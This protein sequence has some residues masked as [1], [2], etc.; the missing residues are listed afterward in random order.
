MDTRRTVIQ[1]TVPTSSEFHSDDE[2]PPDPGRV[3][4]GSPPKRTRRSPSTTQQPT[5][6][7]IHEPA[8]RL[9]P[10][11]DHWPVKTRLRKRVR[12]PVLLE[13]AEVAVLYSPVLVSKGWNAQELLADQETAQVA[14]HIATVLANHAAGVQIMPCKPSL[15]ACLAKLD[16]ARHLIFNLCEGQ[17]GRKGSEAQIARIIAEHGFIHTGAPYAA[18]ARTANKWTT[19]KILE[20]AGLP[21]PAC[22]II[23]QSS[24][25]QLEVQPPVM[26][27]PIAEDGSIGITQRSLARTAEEALIMV[28][29]HLKKYR[30][31][32]LVEEYIA[33][34]EINVA[35][36]GDGSPHIL[37]IAEIDFTWTDDPLEKFVTYASKWI[38]D[39]PE[40]NG[41]PGI[42]PAHLTTKE[43]KIIEQVSLESWHR[44]HLSG[45]ARIDMRLRGGI[46]YILEVNAN[47][48]LA[49]DAGFFRSAATAGYSYE[50]MIL[51]I[52]HLALKR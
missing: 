38:S 2:E 37:P 34:R 20:A 6:I 4:L 9:Q 25:W 39:S 42:C 43:R 41:T 48:D 21:T 32:V 31:A 13:A 45:Y 35:I 10:R 52:A 44:L 26:I 7:Q 18:I 14:A 23:R 17:L 3:L 24:T 36:W 49:P 33:G 27:K 29:Q 19:K 16:P 28:G 50:A 8:P 22:Q 30:Q 11:Q 51:H 1:N 5:T 47:P 46:P 40:F 12:P 15:E